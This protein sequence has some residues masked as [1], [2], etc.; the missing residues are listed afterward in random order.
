MSAHRSQHS[1]KLRGAINT[2]IKQQVLKYVAYLNIMHR[3][4]LRCF[5]AVLEVCRRRPPQDGATCSTSADHWLSKDKQAILISNTASACFIA[6]AA[7]PA[8]PAERRP[9]LVGDAPSADFEAGLLFERF[10][11]AGGATGGNAGGRLDALAFQKMWRE[12]DKLQQLRRALGP[13]AAGEGR[14]GL[15]LLDMTT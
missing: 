4:R 1:S 10:A 2:K 6:P 13:S 12:R 11:A 15:A 5:L 7:A 8:A 9:S 3:S 14:G